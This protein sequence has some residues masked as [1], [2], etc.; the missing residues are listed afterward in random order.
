MLIAQSPIGI[1]IDISGFLFL[2]DLSL[3]VCSM[4]GLSESIFGG[5]RVG[6]GIGEG[7]V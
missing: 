6:L 2:L 4:D 7:E 3:L 1:T 5:S